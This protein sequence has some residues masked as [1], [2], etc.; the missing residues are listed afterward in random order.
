MQEVIGFRGQQGLIDDV[1]TNADT[2][3]PYCF[4]TTPEGCVPSGDIEC[5]SLAGYDPDHIKL[6]TKL[7]MP[8]DCWN[9]CDSSLVIDPD[10]DTT[11]DIRFK[12]GEA[13]N[14]DYNVYAKVVDATEGNSGDPSDVIEPCGVAE[15]CVETQVPQLVFF[16][17]LEVLVQG[18]TN[19]LERA[20]TSTLYA[21]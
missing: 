7:N 1:C 2:E 18:V 21:Y 16:Y 6:R 8:T 17:T 19:P 10:D 3:I 14:Q 5:T 20:K 11:Y 12:L 15:G 13:P 9:S 4:Y